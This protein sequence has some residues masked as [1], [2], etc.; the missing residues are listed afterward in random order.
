M[1]AHEPLGRRAQVRAERRLRALALAQL[2]LGG[3]RQPRQVRG[4]AHVLADA[5]QALAVERA[6]RLEVLEL[7]AERAHSCGGARPRPRARAWRRRC[8]RRPRSPR[9]GRPPG[10]SSSFVCETGGEDDEKIITVGI[11]R[12]ISAASWS[13]PLGIAV[14][15]PPLADRLLREADQPVVERDR[16]DR[17]EVLQ[18]DRAALLGRRLLAG[19]VGLV[20]HRGE[21]VGVEVALVEQHLGAA[22]DRRHHARARWSRRRWCRRRPRGASPTS[23][24]ASAAR[25]VARKRVA[26]QLHRRRAGVRRL[27]GEHRHVALDA[28]RAEHGR[29]RL[30][31]ALEHR[32]LL[33][34][35]LEVGARAAQLRA[36]LVHPGEVDVVA[37]DARP[38]A[39]RRRGRAGRGPRR[40]RA[41]PRRRTSRTGCARSARPPRRPSR[42]A[43]ARPAG[44]PL[45]VRA[46]RLERGEDPERAVEPAAGG[47]RVDVRADDHEAVLLARA[48]RPRRCPPAST[49]I[50]TGSSSS[51][52]RRNSRALH[53]LV[54]PA[55]APRAVRPAGQLGP[56]RAGPRGRGRR[57]SHEATAR[58]GAER[59]R[60]EAAVARLGADLAAVV[61][62]RRRGSTSGA[63]CRSS[64]S[65]SNRS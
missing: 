41:C 22:G 5:A 45:G 40:P 31:A 6:R 29:R 64:D 36:R 63:R 52:E 44:C 58:G 49:S 1:H 32:A 56:A 28:E 18:L 38:R 62:Q 33:D 12:A 2:L 21:L 39:A 26:P 24:I 8:G 46:Q 20:E 14:S 65:P 43:A 61:D 30:V 10:V 55:H 51:R 11:S 4:L 17:P 23:R 37:G 27:A 19:L 35:Q 15:L 34:V 47:H 57:P 9:A 16:R 48:G 25:A 50:S 3:E 13:G 53:P 7:L 54:G 59:A 60:H 42:R